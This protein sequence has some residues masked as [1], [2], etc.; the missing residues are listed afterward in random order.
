MHTSMFVD[1]RRWADRWTLR[2]V[3]AGFVCAGAAG[4][5]G[6]GAGSKV[7]TSTAELATPIKFVQVAS[8][9]PQTNQSTVA[10]KYAAA[11][12]GGNLNVIAV[13]WN[14][15]TSS[16]T[17]V[18]DTSGNSYALAIGPTKYST[19]LSQSIYYAKNIAGAAAGA[20]T[21]TV[22]FSAAA[23]YVD[24]RILEYSGLDTVAPFDVAAGASGTV[25]S[26]DSGAL[27]T[28]GANELLFA[29]NMTTG[30]TNAAGAA[31]TS[32]IVTN[33]DGD[34]AED[35]VLANAGTFHGV[36]FRAGGGG[37]QGAGVRAPSPS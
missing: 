20:N 10:V 17:S 9:T 37:G 16:V 27:T 7:E 1:V 3:F 13:G 30:W 24:I 5:C 22:K 15:T 36:A 28:S 25:A 8:A 18:N 29:A 11:Q 26:N 35:Q 33:P 4:G 14:D 34:I 31:F 32:R 19:L 6:S 12:T 23:T 2:R 21:V